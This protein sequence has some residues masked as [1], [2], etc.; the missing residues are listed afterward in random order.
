MRSATPQLSR[1]VAV[2]TRPLQKIRAKAIIS[3]SPRRMTAAFVLSP[4]RRP[5]QNPAPTATMFWGGGEKPGGAALH[6]HTEGK[7]AGEAGGAQAGRL[8]GFSGP[9]DPGFH[10][11]PLREKEAGTSSHSWGKQPRG[12]CNLDSEGSIRQRKGTAQRRLHLNAV[13]TDFLFFF[14][15]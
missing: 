1:N 12:L 13:C 14:F 15:K 8:A 2:D 5:S 9:Q 4:Q 10:S 7:C 11:G 6:T 3:M